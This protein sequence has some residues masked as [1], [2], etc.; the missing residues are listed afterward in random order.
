MLITK[1][2]IQAKN[3]IKMTVSSVPAMQMIR[4]AVIK[5]AN[6]H[7]QLPSSTRIPVNVINMVIIPIPNM[8]SKGSRK[9]KTAAS[10]QIAISGFCTH[11]LAAASR[12]SRPPSSYIITEKIRRP[13]IPVLTKTRN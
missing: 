5:H 2:P 11:H 6:I 13:C 12:N 9:T 3:I 8:M 10:T 4:F 7:I 1:L